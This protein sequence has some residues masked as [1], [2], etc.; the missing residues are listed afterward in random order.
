MILLLALAPPQLLFGLPAG[1]NREISSAAGPSGVESQEAV[2][3][4]GEAA[5]HADVG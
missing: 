5:S 3:A 2:R 1:R 4:G